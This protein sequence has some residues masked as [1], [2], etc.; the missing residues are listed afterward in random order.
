MIYP[1][2]NTERGFSAVELMVAIFVGAAFILTGY[3]LYGIIAVNGSSAQ[4]QTIASNLAYTDLRIAA[5]QVGST[6]QTSS[7]SPS[8]PPGTALPSGSTVAVSTSCPYGTTSKV[9][10]V[11]VTVNYGTNKV[12][13]GIYATQ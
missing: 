6:C 10:E 9:S 2:S 11:S 7:T 5:G 1:I 4:E 3:Q 8:I 13:H 12:T